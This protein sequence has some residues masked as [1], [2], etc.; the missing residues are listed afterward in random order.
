MKK[1]L[2][3]K[4]YIDFQSIEKYGITDV[5]ELYYNL[6]YEE[7]FNHE[8]N[9]DLAGFE[10]GFVTSLGAVAV[11]TGIY[12][13]RSPKDKYIVREP[14]TENDIWWANPA[15]NRSDNNP[16]SNKVW[17]SLKET[18]IKQLCGKKLYVCLLYT[19]PSPRDS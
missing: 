17:D 1:K 6:S 8:T 7:L 14:E 12:T 4:S 19:S 16:I 10:K 9:P 18:S 2:I 3:E 5:K 11:D 15:L 13:G